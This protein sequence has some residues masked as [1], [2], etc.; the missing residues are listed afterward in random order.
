MHPDLSVELRQSDEMAN[1]VAE[2]LDLTIRIGELRDSSLVVRNLGVTHRCAMASAAYLDQ[3]APIKV[4]SDLTKH[5]CIAYTGVSQPNAWLFQNARGATT[6][7]VK[8]NLQC[9]NSEGIRSAVLSDMGVSYSPTWLF[10]TELQAG[11]VRKVFPNHRGRVVPVHAVY[12]AGRAQPL[13]IRKLVDFLEVEFSRDPFV[14]KEQ[15]EIE[16]LVATEANY[17]RRQR[18]R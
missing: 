13:R 11:T 15:A 2:G 6:I 12:A 14:S 17:K 18:A 16:G 3:A 5:N 1:V 7:R 8:G 4:P 9:S 10:M